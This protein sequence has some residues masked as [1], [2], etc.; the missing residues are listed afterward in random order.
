MAEKQST[1]NV[2]RSFLEK[3]DDATSFTQENKG[4]AY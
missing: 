3:R 1:G 2:C 4:R